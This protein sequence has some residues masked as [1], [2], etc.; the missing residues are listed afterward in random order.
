LTETCRPVEFYG[1][2]HVICDLLFVVFDGFLISESHCHTHGSITL[3]HL[4]SNDPYTLFKTIHF[5]WG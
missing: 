3:S 4:L 2:H 1:G 5:R